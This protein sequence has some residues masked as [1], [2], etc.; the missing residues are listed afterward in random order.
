MICGRWR[1]LGIFAG[2]WVA[3]IAAASLVNGGYNT[4]MAPLLAM[5]LGIV[6]ANTF[7][8]NLVSEFQPSNAPFIGLV[9][10]II[11]LTVKWLRGALLRRELLQVDL[12]FVVITWI[13]GLYVGRFWIEW[14]LP[15]LAVWL[16]RQIRDGLD[17]KPSGLQRR[18][19][20][21]GLFAVAASVMYLA[22]TADSGGRW[23]N[24][25]RYP[26]LWTPLHEFV[27]ELPE[28]GGTLYSVEMGTFYGIFHR[29]PQ[30]N[31]RFALAMEPGVMPTSDLKVLRAVQ[32]TGR[33]VEYK[34]WFDKMT[35]K[36]R[37][38]IRQASKPE[39]P[40]VEFRQFF[41]GWMG[42]K[43]PP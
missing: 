3:A 17:L 13:M 15:A 11:I 5:K 35:S 24:P 6:Q 33:L 31:F 37:I 26:L 8:T 40:Q 19:E 41:D 34:P 16:T 4:V 9:V 10:P 29:L 38:L 1:S 18:W 39:W 23:T 30:A 12:C 36:D 25:L 21:V 27:A 28:E 22:Q 42:R 32:S 7:G 43:V 20:S 14:G 2:A